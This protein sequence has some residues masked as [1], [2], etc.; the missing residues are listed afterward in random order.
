M[1]NDWAAENRF[2]VTDFK[3]QNDTV[4]LVNKEDYETALY[5]IQSPNLKT[6]TQFFVLIV[7]DSSTSSVGSLDT[8]RLVRKWLS[9]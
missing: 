8:A 1:Y 3:Y 2:H 9:E 5:Q 4:L 6:E 7:M